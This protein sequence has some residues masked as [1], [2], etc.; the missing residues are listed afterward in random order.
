MRIRVGA[1]VT[2]R[3]LAGPPA[4]RTAR[5]AYRPDARDRRMAKEPDIATAWVPIDWVER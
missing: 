1:R 4:G 3:T 5:A 2:R